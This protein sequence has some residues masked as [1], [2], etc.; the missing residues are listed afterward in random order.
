MQSGEKTSPLQTQRAR[1]ERVAAIVLTG[2][3]NDLDVSQ[4]ELAARL[5][6]TRNMIANLETGRRSVALSDFLLI[7]TALNIHP[8]TLLQRILRW[9]QSERTDSKRH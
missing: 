8:E 1:W 5:G 2:T 4:R 3:R 9:G 7:A 6:W